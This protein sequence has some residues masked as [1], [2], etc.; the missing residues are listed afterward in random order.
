MTDDQEAQEERQESDAI[1]ARGEAAKELNRNEAF[2]AVML[3]LKVDAD[4]ATKAAL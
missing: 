4:E 3:S 2:I 1:V